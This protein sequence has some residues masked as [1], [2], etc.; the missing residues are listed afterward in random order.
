VSY[1]AP[2]TI[3][4]VP[5]LRGAVK[6]TSNQARV[7][8]RDWALTPNA[9]SRLLA[10]LDQ[11]LDSSGERYLEMRRRLVQYFDRR[12][13]VHPDDLADE[14]LNRIAR[15]LEEGGSMAGETPA[16]SCY[17]VARFV[18]HEYLRRGERN[19]VS[20]DEL[21][22]HQEPAKAPGTDVSS[23]EEMREKMKSC[24]D[25]CLQGLGTEA[26][27]LISQY[28]SGEQREKIENRRVLAARLGI[29]MNA[30]SIRACRIRERLED[31]VVKCLAG[32]S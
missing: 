18:F 16:H 1:A 8:K 26:Y 27:D 20:L 2:A 3:L 31:C 21:Q 4:S 9:W 7:S 29:T 19:Q 14:T 5:A 28:Y 17:I 30:L 13:C 6:N 25:E 22:N 15:R 12:N 11:G 32:K 10:W 24:L 23:E